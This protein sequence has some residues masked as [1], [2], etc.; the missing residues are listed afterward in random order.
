LSIKLEGTLEGLSLFEQICVLK[1]VDLHYTWA[2][3]CC[4]SM[5]VAH[6]DK[7]DQVGWF[8]VG[9][10][11]FGLARDGCFR[12]IGCDNIEEDGT[13]LMAAQGIQDD[14]EPTVA[15][16]TVSS[17]G[18]VT[19]IGGVDRYLADDPVL[20]QL[21]IPP[22]SK[23]R[24]C[25]R[26]TIHK[27]EAMIQ[28]KSPT[29]ATTRIVANINPNIGFLPAPLLDFIMK[30]MAGVLLA[31]LQAAARKIGKHPKTNV[32]A[33]R[34]RAEAPFYRDWLLAKLQYLCKEK[35]WEMPP[36]TVFDYM[37]RDE[38]R[39]GRGR[40]L[41]RVRTFSGAAG[42]DNW[43]N[44]ST[45]Q[46]GDDELSE[47]S[48]QAGSNR[49][50]HS[51]RIRKFFSEFENRSQQKKALK[52]AEERQRAAE[53]L[54]PKEL[55]F[56]KQERLLELKSAIEARKRLGS[57]DFRRARSAFEDVPK[58]SFSEIVT[59]RLNEHDRFTRVLVVTS[60]MILLFAMLH[61]L[62]VMSLPALL[63]TP[64]VQ[65]AVVVAYI[66]LCG[67][68]HFALCDV[69]LVYAFSSLDVGQK[70]GREVKLFYSANVRIAVAGASLL[71]FTI[72]I[73]TASAK[74]LALTLLKSAFQRA[75][76][77]MEAFENGGTSKLTSVSRIVS[78]FR[79]VI[80]LLVAMGNI[81]VTFFVRS[82]SFGR[83][84]IGFCATVYALFLSALD[85][86]K[87][88]SSSL[89]QGD[90]DGSQC[91]L[92]WREEAFNTAKVLFMNSA[93]FLL[94]ILII[95][96]LSTR[97]VHRVPIGA[98]AR[99]SAVDDTDRSADD[100]L[101]PTSVRT[102]S[103]AASTSARPR[104]NTSYDT[105]PE[106]EAVLSPGLKSENGSESSRSKIPNGSRVRSWTAPEARL[107]RKY[108][109]R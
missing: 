99:A 63:P 19:S 106:N 92:P 8:I 40:D 76:T 29:S 100:P 72:S 102:A 104:A 39:L 86:V 31:K 79:G 6:L 78:G 98:G 109:T 51:A 17:A 11:N 101:L 58:S 41:L 27:L 64:A 77:I 103:H 24:G 23:R 85:D 52:I 82:N 49:S 90:E 95:F 7:L 93:V 30:H 75:S 37:E 71:V 46:Q 94:T 10:P 26:M 70:A 48:S 14:V 38:A 16:S 69:A 50:L 2:P 74:V 57:A 22:V 5:T 91:R 105:I 13:I 21:E 44:N 81:F 1:E 25:G 84:A 9:M 28:I 33:Q 88:Q 15:V 87:T 53:R 20:Q 45:P 80:G 66:L 97:R 83:A 56:D 108:E 4:S 3:F 12:A 89:I 47:L 18:S 55:T 61:P 68:V 43:S 67:L 54:K 42:D 107:L 62:T 60:L 36:G 73:I 32:H 65:D 59:D 34:M 96:H 35:G